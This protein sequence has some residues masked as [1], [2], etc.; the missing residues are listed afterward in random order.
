MFWSRPRLL[1]P[2]VDLRLTWDDYPEE[3]IPNDGT[4]LHALERLLPFLATREGLDWAAVHIP[5]VNR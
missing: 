1:A 4:I 3:P 2:L 5:G